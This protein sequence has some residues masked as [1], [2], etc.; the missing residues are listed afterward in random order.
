[1]K[2]EIRI[3]H[4]EMIECQSEYGLA[5][6]LSSKGLPMKGM[7]WPEPDYE[8]YKFKAWDDPETL[9]RVICYRNK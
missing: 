7:F 1:M 2:K 4:K 6:L 5:L 8:N 9:D 3:S